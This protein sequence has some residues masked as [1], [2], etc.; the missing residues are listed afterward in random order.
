MIIFTF[1]WADANETTFGVEH[2]IEDENV[3]RLLIEEE[4]GDFA[5]AR[6]E[7]V[8]PGVGLL[9]VGRK[10]W[11]WIGYDDGGTAGVQPLFFGR[12]VGLPQE[13]IGETVFLEFLARPSDFQTVKDTLADTLRVFPFWD[14]VWVPRDVRDDAD[15]VLNAY[16]SHWHVDRITHAVTISDINVVE[17]GTIDL[18]GLVFYD[19]AQARP[20][21]P[22]V[23]KVHV[24]A[25]VSWRQAGAGRVD[26]KQ[27]LI[28]AFRAAG[29]T[30]S[31]HVSSY[32]GEGL[33]A[34]WPNAGDRIGSGWSVHAGEAVRVEGISQSVFFT[35]SVLAGAVVQ[36]PLWRFIPTY[37]LAFDAERSRTERVVFDL[38][39]DTQ[40]MITD[41]GDAEVLLIA[42]SSI[43]I[44]EPIDAGDAT[45][46]GDFRRNSYFLQD[47]GKLSV[48]YLIALARARLLFRARAV[49]VRVETKM[50]DV[51]AVTCRHNV[52]VVDPRLPGGQAIGKVTRVRLEIDG[53]QG[54][55]VGLVS[56]GCTVGRGGTLSPVVGTPD[57]VAD[58]YVESDFQTRSGAIIVPIASEVGYTDYGA[59]QPNVAE[60]SDEG[61]DLLRMSRD[62]VVQSIQIIGGEAAQAAIIGAGFPSIAVAEEA[63]NQL[64]TEV[65]VELVPLDTGP[66]EHEITV[67]LTDLLVPKT[68]DLE[69]GST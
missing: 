46:I 24:E 5:T 6:V 4:E 52:R 12:L 50:D 35:D 43:D 40:E 58:G 8:N 64:F 21:Q 32:T 51:L 59:Q 39:A 49:E 19:S 57:Y 45:P 7:V 20:L 23:R 2:E 25:D 66:F 61:V 28:D 13:M 36:F 48:E 34:D 37:I 53:D 29:T 14:P 1:A 55:V 54:L 67:T 10:R 41:A 16:N 47:R 69:A 44:S 22:P 30:L 65:V 3:F 42:L 60:G 68:I 62:R 63:L 56:I 33:L 31:G 27:A 11:A 18:A 15:E 17:D 26:L 9:N 38:E